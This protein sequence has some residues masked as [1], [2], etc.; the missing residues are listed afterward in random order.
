MGV[1]FAI[2]GQAVVGV[3]ND[4]V[5]DVDLKVNLRPSSGDEAPIRG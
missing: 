3:R 2:V 4:E 1:A 5:G